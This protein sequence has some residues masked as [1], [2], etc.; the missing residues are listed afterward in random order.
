MLIE[1]MDELS[2]IANVAHKILSTAI[3]P[4][5]LLGEEC[6]V[7]AS[8]GISIY[9]RDGEDEQALMK[10]A[11]M[12]MYVAKE[13]GK[14]NYQFYSKDIQSKSNKRFSIETNLR[15]ALGRNELSLEYQAKL[16]F[17]TGMITGVEALLRWDN[18][19]LGSVTPSQFIP[20]AEET[21]LIVPIGRWVMKTACAQ[22]V[23][24]QR[25]G[26]P[27]VCMAV[28]LSLRQLMDDNLLKDIKAALDDS[29]MAPNLLELEITES[30][31]MQ[32]PVRLIEVLTNIKKIG[33]RLAIDNFGTGYASLTQL[34]NFPIDTIK[35][36]K[37]FIRNLP[38]DS[39]DKAITEAII[40]MGKTLSLYCCRRRCGNGGAG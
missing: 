33:V 18:P 1:E 37:S 19:Y 7:T 17:K 9:P 14:N 11:D 8:I 31:L 3:Q 28:N 34:R 35:L 4:I 22:N 38:Q 5:V 20:V 26:L 21:G 15:R 10:N 12:A 23:A 6:R 32:N 16:D 29:G 2:Q 27:P 24:W 40:A 13:G 39:K 25:Q 30:M 36:D